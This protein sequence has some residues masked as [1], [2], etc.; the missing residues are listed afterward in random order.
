M[1]VD[2]I[3]KEEET[4]KNISESSVEAL[5]NQLQQLTN[6]LKQLEEQHN[7]EIEAI[8]SSCESKLNILNEKKENALLEV[9]SLRSQIKL[10]KSDVEKLQKI[11]DTE[12][13]LKKTR[14]ELLGISENEKNLP[15]SEQ[16]S[17]SIMEKS[18]KQKASPKPSPKKTDKK[19][20]GRQ[21]KPIK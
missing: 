4:M 14:A 3:N 5:R 7:N 1:I 13:R 2:W 12:E 6:T 11:Y 10:F 20:V 8:N 16:K 19:A 15:V 18:R 9:E 21:A 17:I